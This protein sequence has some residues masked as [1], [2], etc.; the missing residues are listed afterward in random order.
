[1]VI[2]SHSVRGS[3]L[4]TDITVLRFGTAGLLLLPIVIKKGLRL[5]PWGIWGGFF[6]AL[7]MGAPYN[8]VTIYGMKFIPA[9]H[10]AGIVNTTMLLLTTLVGVLVLGEHT[11]R[12]KI[13]GII[14][15]LAGIACL[16]LA[17][18]HTPHDDALLGHMLVMVGGI[19]WSVYALTTKAWHI[20]PLHTTSCVSVCSAIMI[21][22]IYFLFLPTNISLNT[23][24][25]SAFQA[26]YQ[27]V[28]NSIIALICYNK[29]IRVLGASTSSA[30]LPLI[31]VAATLLAVPALGEI[32]LLQEWLGIGLAALGVLLATGTVSHW[33]RR[34]KG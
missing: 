28:L 8:I 17:E 29:A 33:L 13:A 2:S 3:L 19:I 11:S 7:M 1:M 12:T 21:L 23:W 4:A 31:P 14:L 30:F 10:A 16:F 6:L 32:P 15:S 34:R 9:S 22:P 27:G 24:Q 20:D 5:G 25:E 18:S 26:G